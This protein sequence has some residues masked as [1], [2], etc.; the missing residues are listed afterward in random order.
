MVAS[1]RPGTPEARTLR[2]ERSLRTATNKVPGTTSL[3]SAA[4]FY[5]PPNIANAQYDDNYAAGV[6]SRYDD[7]V[8]GSGLQDPA[9][10]YFASTSDIIAKIGQISPATVVWG[11]IDTSITY[12]NYT[13]SQLF[14]QINEWLAI[15]ASGIFCDVF[16]YSYGVSRAR[17]N[18]ILNYIHSLG[19]GAI[20]NVY[21][22][23]ECLGSQ[24]DVVFNPTGT[25]T[26]AN[27]T[28][29]IL[30]ESWAFNSD[31]GGYATPFYATFSDLKT[32][33]EAVLAYRNNLGVRIYSANIIAHTGNTES[34]L[35][36]YRGMAESLARVF[37][38]DG[39]CV[40]SS[41]YAATG[42]DIGVIAPRDWNWPQLP[43][44]QTGTYLLNGPWTQVQASDL[45]ITV[46]YD[47]SIP[48]HTYTRL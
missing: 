42:S 9:N 7:V 44:R 22:P 30:L 19:V 28:D 10:T 35:A 12:G 47:N 5:S 6:F 37:R 26:V 13:L 34:A 33:A 3:R 15:G 43:L 17:Q 41:G 48:T 32:R 18:A 36:G 14:T 25:L 29:V 38:L 24:V 20:M 27:S 23:D 40:A 46:N 2:L 8:F 1:A 31:T 39:S 16:G 4:I 45:G 11:Y 21:N